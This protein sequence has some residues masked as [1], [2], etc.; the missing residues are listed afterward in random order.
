MFAIFRAA[1]SLRLAA[2]MVFTSDVFALSLLSASPS[3]VH[4]MFERTSVQAQSAE[5]LLSRD[6][7]LFRPPTLL[8]NMVLINLLHP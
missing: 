7:D 8:S 6:R 1:R 3:L 2:A 5:G 4:Y